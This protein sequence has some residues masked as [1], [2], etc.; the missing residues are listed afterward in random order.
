M[1][2]SVAAQFLRKLGLTEVWCLRVQFQDALG[3]THFSVL[4]YP[5]VVVLLI[6]G[7]RC[8][9][10]TGV[11]A[12]QVPGLLKFDRERRA[13]LRLVVL[14]MAELDNHIHYVVFLAG[15]TLL[16]RFTRVSHK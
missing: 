5:Y 2:L 4:P 11:I 15:A 16:L 9:K 3:H 1:R 10:I 13:H 6:A 12:A 14:G 7:Q 8:L